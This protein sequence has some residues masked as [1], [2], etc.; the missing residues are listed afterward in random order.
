M[1]EERRRTEIVSLRF[2][3]DERAE[4]E[5]KAAKRGE[6]LSTYLRR[7][8][9]DVASASS[10]PSGLNPHMQVWH[11]TSW[12]VQAAPGRVI[13]VHSQPYYSGGR[14]GVW[15]PSDARRLAAALLQAADLAEQSDPD[16]SE[17]SA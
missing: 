7:R 16:E 14:V 2:T 13:G 4:L 17:E 15:E 9:L 11:G 5:R 3:A 12:F 10:V 6:P 1:S 8:S